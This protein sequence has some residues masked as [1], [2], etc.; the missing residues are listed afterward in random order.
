[1]DKCL[2]D[3]LSDVQMIISPIGSFYLVGPSL[4]QNIG[5]KLSSVAYQITV[6]IKDVM[7]LIIQ[8]PVIKTCINN[9]NL[10]LKQH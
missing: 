4:A 10:N 1:M 2:L 6:L 3:K 8:A 7:C 9:F 5:S